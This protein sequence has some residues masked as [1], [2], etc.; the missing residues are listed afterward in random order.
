MLI[1]SKRHIALRNK[2]LI[3]EID[4]LIVVCNNNEIK[5]KF[6]NQCYLKLCNSN[7]TLYIS[8]TN[9]LLRPEV[10]TIAFL[11]C[12]RVVVRD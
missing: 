5:S 12:T 4:F 8:I 1:H 9:C 7:S 2:H 3:Y 10:I 11:K 6:L